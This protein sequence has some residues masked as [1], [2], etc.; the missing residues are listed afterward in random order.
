MRAG[1]DRGRGAAGW[2]AAAAAVAGLVL[3]GPGSAAGA[4][5]PPT[6]PPAGPGSA[7]RVGPA[8]APAA[9]TGTAVRVG[10]AGAPAAGTGTAVRVGPA[11]AP[12][13][14]TGTAVRVGPAGAPAAGTGTAVR[15]GP[16][17]APAA[18]TGSAVPV[19]PAGAPAAPA[20]A[21]AGAGS[22]AP[23]GPSLLGDPNARVGSLAGPGPL[24][25]NGLG[26]PACRDPT[27]RAQLSATARADCA[28]SGVAVASAP[29]ENY[30]FDV[31]IDTGLLGETAENLIEN[32][33]L[34]PVWMALV[35][36][37][38]V[39]V[40]GL[41]WCFSI[42]LLGAGTF[43]SVTRGLQSMRDALTTP[44]LAP[45]LAVAAV[46]AVYNGIV[47]RRVVET[48]GQVVLLLAMT[49]GGLW[50]IAAPQATVGQASRWANQ[51]SLGVL[52]AA[53]T[54]DPGHPLRSLDDALRPLFAVAVTGPWCYLEFGDVAWCRE[55]GRLDPRL[56]AAA[57]AVVA[58]DRAAASSPA[59]RRQAAAEAVA[60]SRARTNGDLFLALP[61]NGPRRNSINADA[62]NPSLL[63]VLCGS[64]TATSCSADTGPQAEFRTEKGTAARVGGLLLIGIGATGM[65]A[66]IGFICMRLI[67]AALLALVYLLLAPVAVLAPAFGDGGRDA[68]RRWSL[69]LLG[70]VVAKLI[71]SVF[72]GVVLLIVRIL[73]DLG[74]LG[75]WTQWILI[76]CFWWLVF[77]HRHRVLENVIHERGEPNHRSSLANK[78]FATRQALK[79]AAPPARQFGGLARRGGERLRHLPERVIAHARRRRTV[80]R[81]AD[82]AGQVARTLDRDHQAAQAVVA[83]APATE[84]RLGELRTRRDRIQRQR[85]AAAAA[86]DRRRTLSL[87]RRQADI[88]ADV[89]AGEAELAQARAAVPAGEERRRRTGLVHDED[90]RARRADL[91][92]RE[93]ELRPL[94]AAAKDRRVG[95][96]DYPGLA[97]LV[98]LGPGEYDRLS[99][100]ERRR[101]ALKIDRE[102]E[103]RRE[104]A[105]AAARLTPAEA[106]DRARRRAARARRSR[107]AKADDPR[108]AR[109]HQ[110]RRE[111]QFGRAGSG[112]G[113]FDRRR[114]SDR[115]GGHRPERE[116]DLGRRPDGDR[117]RRPR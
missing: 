22:A 78:L 61:S 115:D 8:G 27:L 53:A 79:L 71:Y 91:L 2:A 38:D 60:V 1:D 92:D 93:A 15:V 45:I 109:R 97:S 16:A 25:A 26:S 102:L 50:V 31:H 46:A 116:L 111:R 33:L 9:G 77:N 62:A 54:G 32:L 19:G 76:V 29:L 12:A 65:F 28:A 68:F 13:A 101:A 73:S 24:V 63:A 85:R 106:A 98:G 52:G 75:W 34:K 108:P 41:E 100:P 103:Q 117:D 48:L 72:L 81:R 74:G 30:Q 7:V 88:E 23:S 11:G 96:R 67:G 95:R 10:P 51:A 6:P 84:L 89:Q 17:G 82:L 39:A 18:S 5:R 4:A 58:H 37:T 56:V 3:A 36:L 112:Y 107:Q 69:R 114:R 55:P 59:E 105:K 21:P 86:G 64:D 40:V 35:W 104:W 90:Q 57:G 20:P 44:W 80:D 49:A 42:D 66:L 94:V 47:R 99:A 110:S 43:R 87:Q 113:D 83:A 70:A 14:G